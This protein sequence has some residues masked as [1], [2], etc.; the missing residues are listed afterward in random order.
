MKNVSRTFSHRNKASSKVKCKYWHNFSC[1]AGTLFLLVVGIFICENFFYLWWE[2]SS[3]KICPCDPMHSCKYIQAIRISIL[4][5][6]SYLHLHYAKLFVTK[7][8]DLILWHKMLKLCALDS[9][10]SLS[11][12]IWSMLW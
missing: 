1:T 8:V 2:F 7:Y 5:I 3:A 10:L 12:K 11:L 6:I 9:P 4:M